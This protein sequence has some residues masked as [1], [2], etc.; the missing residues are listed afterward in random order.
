MGNYI[1]KNSSDEVINK[2]TQ[3][4]LGSTIDYFS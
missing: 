1:L 2:T 3:I 4:F